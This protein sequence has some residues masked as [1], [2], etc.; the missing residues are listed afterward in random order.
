MLKNQC[1][2]N[3]TFGKESGTYSFCQHFLSWRDNIGKPLILY[4]PLLSLY[5]L[6]ISLMQQ[7][8]TTEQGTAEIIEIPCEWQSNWRQAVISGNIVHWKFCY[9]G[10]PLVLSIAETLSHI[11]PSLFGL[12]LIQIWTRSADAVYGSPPSTTLSMIIIVLCS[13]FWF[14]LVRVIR[15]TPAV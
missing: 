2:K 15:T 5:T 4:Q 11:R 3:K 12:F 13:L 9:G 8:Y 7:N 14:S 1:L 10:A 6:N